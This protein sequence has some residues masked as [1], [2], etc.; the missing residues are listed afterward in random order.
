MPIFMRL[1][2][3]HHW[4]RRKGRGCRTGG[5]MFRV[6]QISRTMKRVT[7]L[8][9]TRRTVMG[10]ILAFLFL[11]ITAVA[12]QLPREDAVRIAEFYRLAEQ[13]QDRVWPNLSKTTA[14]LLLVTDKTAFLTRHL[15]P[16]KRLTS[17]AEDS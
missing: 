15:A 4:I 7:N 5:R 6:A 16:P 1:P 2:R 10:G 17:L 12:Q 9:F 13:I 11:T 8:L 3:Y 14:P